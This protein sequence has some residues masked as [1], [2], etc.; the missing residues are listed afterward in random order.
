M[1]HSKPDSPPRHIE[2]FGEAVK[3]D[4][5]FFGPFHF[6]KT[7]GLISIKGD[8][9]IGGIMTDD[10][11][12]TTGKGHDLFKERLFSDR[13]GRIIG[14]VDKKEFCFFCHL[15]RNFGKIRQKTILFPEGQKIGD[16]SGKEGGDTIDR[17][18]GTWDKDIIPWIDKGE[19]D[20]SDPFLRTDEG[21]NLCLGL[22]LTPNLL[23]YHWATAVLNSIIPS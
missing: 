7:E 16:S 12:V 6:Q 8:F 11:L 4:S 21:E 17:I 14:I 18:A 3:F 9:G 5:H 10:D 1:T 20:V 13:R 23:S 22:S 2:G 15:L 19:G